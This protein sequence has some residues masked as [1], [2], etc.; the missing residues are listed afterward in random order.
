MGSKRVGKTGG[1]HVPKNRLTRE[2]AV[3][4]QYNSTHEGVE[5]L[6]N[7]VKPVMRYQNLK[8][9]GAVLI[10]ICVVMSRTALQAQQPK[11]SSTSFE[12]QVPIEPMPV[13][14]G[15]RT[16]L[17]YELHITNF[18]TNSVTLERV[19]ILA[20]DHND[21]VVHTYEGPELVSALALAG[22]RPDQVGKSTVVA[23]GQRMILFVWLPLEPGIK[24]PSF[25]RHK[26][27]YRSD[28]DG[29][30][31][32]LDGIRVNVRNETPI[33]LGPPVRGGPWAAI[34]EPSLNGGHR[35]AL[36][37]ING[38]ARIPARFAVDWI[39][40]GPDG[41][42]WQGDPSVM[43]NWFGHGADVLA[44]T[45]AKV[46]ALEDG[47]PEPTPKSFKSDAGNYIALD[48]GGGRFAFYEHLRPGSIRVKV[49]E[50]V[51][52]GQVIASLG[53]SGSVSSGPHLHFHVAD[54]NSPL[55]AEG[56]PF[57]FTRFDQF[58]AFP[59]NGTFG[60][61]QPWVAEPDATASK[62]TMEFPLMLT[63][64]QFGD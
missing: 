5:L 6:S 43:S 55:G 50:Q 59:S 63:V 53:G 18:K 12:I 47:F 19:D 16:C 26:I 42:G 45:D 15:G 40:L 30:L 11:A 46:A 2:L 14:I 49:G 8:I 61:G 41:R 54:G 60:S 24:A 37:A 35:R 28:S 44:V 27:S 10:C 38:K 25:L 31:G 58:G 4:A 48:L 23:P 32:A 17:V 20:E 62:R 13:N 36:F 57:V 1:D 34:Y 22:S 39:K 7:T 51:R 33:V 56:L 9:I 29:E 52:T 64:V 21:A 3:G